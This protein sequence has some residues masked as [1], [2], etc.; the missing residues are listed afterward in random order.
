MALSRAG[1]DRNTQASDWTVRS[2]SMPLRVP[3][4]AKSRVHQTDLLIAARR[5]ATRSREDAR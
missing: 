3:Q 2:G 1:P 4:T 5:R